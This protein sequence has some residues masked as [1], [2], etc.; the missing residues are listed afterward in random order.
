MATPRDAFEANG[1]LHALTDAL[2][3]IVGTEHVLTDEPTR[4]L[5]SQD[6]YSR[7]RPV[8]VVVRP[9]DTASLAA[10]IAAATH[11]GRA[12]IPRG[13]GMSYTGG[14]L[15]TESGS[16]L[17]DMA[18]MNRVLEINRE[19]MTVTVECGCTWQALHEALKGTGL[20]TPFWGTL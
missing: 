20:R 8:D 4:A 19:D 2:T 13:G 3:D 16:V 17:V 5:Y 14:Y 6:I 10:V 12:V 15:A 7:G 9:N 11:A 18:R 1:D